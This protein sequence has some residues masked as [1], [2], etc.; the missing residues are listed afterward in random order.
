MSFNRRI[1]SNYAIFILMWLTLSQIFRS[2][3]FNRYIPTHT[4][5]ADHIN[6]KIDMNYLLD[7][8]NSLIWP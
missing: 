1:N 7:N 2:D 4:K 6:K 8:V 5:R 3:K